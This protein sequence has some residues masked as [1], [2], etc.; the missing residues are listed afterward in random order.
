MSTT[1]KYW[2]N[3]F[4]SA[5]I[6]FHFLSLLPTLSLALASS[7]GCYRAFYDL[8]KQREK[9]LENDLFVNN[10]WKVFSSVCVLRSSGYVSH[11]WENIFQTIQ[12]LCCVFFDLT[13]VKI[14]LNSMNFGKKAPRTRFKMPCSTYA[15]ENFLFNY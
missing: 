4:F 5:C 6:S 7:N 13:L 11:L 10:K 12:S 14:D 9:Y 15:I 2:E 3:T 8:W 1:D